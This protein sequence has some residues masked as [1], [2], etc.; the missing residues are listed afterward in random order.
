MPRANK[1]Q[2]KSNHAHKYYLNH[3]QER[4]NYQRNYL[5]QKPWRS[6]LDNTRR[7]ASKNALEYD[8]TT[9][10]AELTYTGKCSLTNI[11]FII[12]ASGPVGKMGLRPFSPSIDRI[13]NSKGYTQDN[14]RWILWA[15]NSFKGSMNDDEML[16]VAK[17]LLQNAVMEA[18]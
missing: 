12:S 1:N 17:A 5:T 16:S 11:P 14:C 6:M 9:D 4:Q 8:L 18:A 7:R 2:L 13:D 15:I 10:W 3:K